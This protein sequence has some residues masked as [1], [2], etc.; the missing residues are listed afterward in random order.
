MTDRRPPLTATQRAEIAEL[1][2]NQGWTYAR[3]AK[4]LGVAIAVVSYRCLMDGIERPGPAPKSP[5]CRGPM[6]IQRGVFQVRRFSARE[7]ARL[8]ELEAADHSYAEI[9]RRLHRRANSIKG[10]LATLARRDERAL[11]DG[12]TAD[13]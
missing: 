1:R 6:T 12:A 2:G 3:I 7:D 8:L 10:R 9:G 11:I 5:V 13:D 4:H